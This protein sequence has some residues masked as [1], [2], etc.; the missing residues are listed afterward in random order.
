MSRLLSLY[1]INMCCSCQQSTVLS[2]ILS[3]DK[4]Y[5]YILAQM[6]VKGKQKNCKT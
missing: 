2:R 6:L 1:Y 3:A 4:Y 5:F